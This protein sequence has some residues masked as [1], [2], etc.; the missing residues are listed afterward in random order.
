M[1]TCYLF[2]FAAS[3][4]GRAGLNSLLLLAGLGGVMIALTAGTNHSVPP[5][6]APLVSQKQGGLEWEAILQAIPSGNAGTN[7]GAALLAAR[8]LVR[9]QPEQAMPWV[10]LG[11]VIAQCQ[12]ETNDAAWYQHAQKTYEMALKLKPELA[13]AMAGMAWVHGGRHEFDLS[14]LW[15]E[16]ALAQDPQHATS[17]GIIGDAAVELGEYDKAFE[18]YQKMMDLRP[19]L[20]SWSRGA[21]LLWLTGDQTKAVLLM[22]QAIRSGG[23]FAENTSWCQARLA[24]MHFNNGALL[25]ASQA[26]APSLANGTK[27]VH[28]LLAAGRI[29]AARG[30]Y[31][32]SEGHYQ[33]V[34]EAGPVLEALAALG[35]LAA[36]QN[37]PDKAERFYAEVEALHLQ[38]RQTGVHDHMEMARFYADHDRKPEEAL[39]LAQEHGDARNTF[40]LDGMAW[41]FF[42]NGNQT[43]AIDYIKRTLKTATPDPSIH[44]HA[45]C[46]AAAARDRASAMLHLQKALDMNPGF[47]LLQS[48][49]ARGLLDELGSKAP[50][51]VVSPAL[52]TKALGGSGLKQLR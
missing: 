50:V 46:I 51:P 22:E 38:H 28:V 37:Q 6:A 11:D 25:P 40:E 24:M 20:S 16:K 4:A 43:Q 17:H 42:Q 12:R 21:H 15:A 3:C 18:H 36:V 8:D 34:L 41:V 10:K 14:V 35:D 26:L 52:D 19:D 39:R 27:N 44:Y 23:P 45:G 47:S 1:K 31:A 9:G 2:P 30:E 29:A 32:E 49:K 48:S 7:Q 5:A 33:K 13:E